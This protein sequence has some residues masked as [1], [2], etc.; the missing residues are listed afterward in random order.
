MSLRGNARQGSD[1]SGGGAKE[2]REAGKRSSENGYRHYEIVDIGVGD[3]RGGVDRNS[4][5]NR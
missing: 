2:E 5:A 3:S 4:S 1:S